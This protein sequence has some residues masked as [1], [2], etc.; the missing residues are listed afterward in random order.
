MPEILMLFSME[1]GPV[2]PLY[3]SATVCVIH[4]HTAIDFCLCILGKM[5]EGPSCVM[6]TLL[7]IS[8][9][10]GRRSRRF[11][12]TWP[13]YI[14]GKLCSPHLSLSPSVCV[15]LSP[16]VHFLARRHNYN[17]YCEVVGHPPA[18]LHSMA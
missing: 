17:M 11:S 7:L 4:V 14:S 5:L 15:S 10:Q 3:C 16:F 2:N 6:C 9:F 1:E 8:V 18:P 12:T 13:H